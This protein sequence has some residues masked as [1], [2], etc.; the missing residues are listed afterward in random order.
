LSNGSARSSVN[1]DAARD[2][3]IS[4]AARHTIPTMF[5]FSSAALAG[6]LMSYGSDVRYAN[7][8]AG[9]YVG[10]HPQGR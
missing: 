8:Q 9:V 5:F 10:Q 2:Q 3:I 4:L 1:L 7:R 6:G